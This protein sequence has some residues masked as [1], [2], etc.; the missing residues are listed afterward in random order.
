M[1][2]IDRRAGPYLLFLPLLVLAGIYS[3]ATAQWWAIASVAGAVVGV[4]LT[5]SIDRY[6]GGATEPVERLVLALEHLL[7][8]SLLVFLLLRA[9]AMLDNSALTVILWIAMVTGLI[10]Y[11]VRAGLAWRRFRREG[12]PG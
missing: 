11:F 1:T 7:A 9:P 5:V 2:P 3:V 12:A 10:A 6:Y 8:L 4:S